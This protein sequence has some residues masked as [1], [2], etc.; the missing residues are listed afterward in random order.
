MFFVHHVIVTCIVRTVTTMN[1]ITTN[2]KKINGVYHVTVT[3]MKCL[4]S[5]QLKYNG[6]QDIS[7]FEC[8]NT[9]IRAN[10]L[11]TKKIKKM[12]T[13]LEKEIDLHVFAISKGCVSGHS[14]QSPLKSYRL[15]LR[16]IEVLKG[17]M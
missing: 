8:K 9:L 3:C 12:I 2:K 13:E 11:T 6:W 5:Y 4:S 15:L 10:Y 1:S 14:P 17:L 16:K 7:C